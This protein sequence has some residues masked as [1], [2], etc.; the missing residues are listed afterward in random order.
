MY[1]EV[2]EK[3]MNSERFIEFLESLRSDA[4]HPI[5]VIADNA[6]YH[7]SK[8]VQAFLEE[9][10]G[11][12]MM[13][14]LPPYAPELNPDEQVWNYAKRE[15]G[16]KSIRNK[17]EMERTIFSIMYAIQGKVDLIKSFFQLDDTQYA[18]L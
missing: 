9:N 10:K 1:F 14:F 11:N 3:R 8:Q 13:A 2:I 7:H 16:K 5:F 12:I 18:S 17:D 15:M 6:R 4:G